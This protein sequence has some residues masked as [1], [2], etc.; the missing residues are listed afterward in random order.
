MTGTTD[1]ATLFID[2]LVILMTTRP[3]RFNQHF[4]DVFNRRGRSGCCLIQGAKQDEIFGCGIDRATT[5][6]RPMSTFKII[7]SMMALDSGVT[8]LSEEIE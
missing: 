7:N 2:S 6:A 8:D 5:R 3:I 4:Q 1:G